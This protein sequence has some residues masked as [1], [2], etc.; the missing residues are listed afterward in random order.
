MT[1]IENEWRYFDEE[2]KTPYPW[3]VKPCLEWLEKLDLQ[4]KRV[5]EYGLGD[6][7]LWYKSKGAFTAGVDRDVSWCLKVGGALCQPLYFGYITAI[8]MFDPFDIVVIDG[9]WRDDCTAYA[10][11]KLKPGGLLIVDNF[12]QPSVE[13]NKWD[14]TQELIKNMPVTIYKEPNHKD[15]TSAVI[16]KPS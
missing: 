2:L 11:D 10:L 4:G 1:R 16:T 13:P 6:S 3:Y 15:W 12:L 14:K 5:F 9:D 8:E 7:T